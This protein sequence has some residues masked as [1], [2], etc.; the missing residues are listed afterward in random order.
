M[1]ARR[2]P[3]DAGRDGEGKRRHNGGTLHHDRGR[4]VLAFAP[5]SR[6]TKRWRSIKSVSRSF[7]LGSTLRALHEVGDP[8]VDVF[9]DLGE[10][11]ACR[12]GLGQ[13]R[14]PRVGLRSSSC[15]PRLLRKV[16]PREAGGHVQ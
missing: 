2:P 5:V 4:R 7:C 16:S 6:L 14:P 3:T 10:A 9:A 1:Y 11:R 12:T 8:V 13:A 15:S